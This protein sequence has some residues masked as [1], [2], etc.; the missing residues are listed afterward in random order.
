MAVKA[1][2]DS[3]IISAISQAGERLGP[4]QQWSAW[5]FNWVSAITNGWLPCSR[6]RLL[7]T[8]TKHK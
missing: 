6:L 3:E 7:L 1:W 8:V 4:R 2:T 5:N